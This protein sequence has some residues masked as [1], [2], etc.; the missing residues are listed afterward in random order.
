MPAMKDKEAWHRFCFAAELGVTADGVQSADG[1]QHA[2][3]AAMVTDNEGAETV[4]VTEGN[5]MDSASRAMLKRKRDL[6]YDLGITLVREDAGEGPHHTADDSEGDAEEGDAS[7][8]AEDI[9][10]KEVAEA[11]ANAERAMQWTGA[12]N[13]EPTTS[14]L[15][16]FDQVLT[17]RLLAL[18]A[19]WLENR[20]VSFFCI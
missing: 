5:T 18:Q 13:V 20:Y 16:Q 19:D 11:W 2:S 14:V 1:E 4:D 7:S 10:G 15:L 9:E 17:Q 3:A 8:L 12:M 6:A